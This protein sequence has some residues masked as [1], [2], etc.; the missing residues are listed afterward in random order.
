[1]SQLR[2]VAL[3]VETANSKRGSICAIGAVRVIDGSII[4]EKTWLCRPPEDL[5]QFA[6]GNIRVHKITPEAVQNSPRFAELWPEILEFIGDD[7]LIC[8]NATFDTSSIREACTA[9]RLPWPKM[10]YGCT[11]VMGRIGFPELN[12]HTLPVLAEHCGVEL[13]NHHDPAQD[14]RAAAEIAIH[15]ARRYRAKSI[16]DLANILRIDLGWITPH[17]Y[18]ACRRSGSAKAEAWFSGEPT[19]YEVSPAFDGP[20]KGH[21]AV[22]TGE[23]QNLSRQNAMDA[24]AAAGAV[25]KKT[26]TAAT[27]ILVVGKLG[28]DDTGKI[29][30]AE[31]MNT[32]GKGVRIV[33]EQGFMD[34]LQPDTNDAPIS[35]AIADTPAP[36]PEVTSA[37]TN[38]LALAPSK[39]TVIPTPSQPAPTSAPPEE[40]SWPAPA[41]PALVMSANTPDATTSP[42]APES[43]PIHEAVPAPYAPPHTHH[44]AN[45]PSSGP[46]IKTAVFA[47]LASVG[48]GFGA[49]CVLAGLVGLTDDPL[50]AVSVLILG[51]TACVPSIWWWRCHKTDKKALVEHRQQVTETQA[52]NAVLQST[53]DTAWIT[54]LPQTPASIDRKWLPVNLVTAVLV[55]LFIVMMS[56]SSPA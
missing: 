9:S 18:D 36:T 3:D 21:T 10:N 19:T 31:E 30:K 2:F 53:G 5:D 32:K 40:V 55:I 49:L 25:T 37:P 38:S 14:A 22:F 13:K 39:L 26:M 24:A 51:L 46:R 17:R 16:F 54:P 33:D 20:L 8:H 11:M 52:V 29:K 47:T 41:P 45:Q 43:A 23:L 48:I 6:A 28:P 34:L 27:T 35:D 42:T 7:P 12:S 56:M 50:I 44:P 15:M 1:M 4:E